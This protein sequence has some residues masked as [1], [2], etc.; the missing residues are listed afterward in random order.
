MSFSERI[1]QQFE[2]IAPNGERFFPSLIFT[3]FVEEYNASTFEYIEQIGTLVTR[4]FPKGR[5]FSIRI[6]FQGDSNIDDAERFRLTL[7]DRRP[8]RFFHPYYDQL[9]LQPISLKYDHSAYNVTVIT[10]TCIETIDDSFPRGTENV[11]GRIQ[12]DK[13]AF[14][15]TV[16]ES[17]ERRTTTLTP[18]EINTLGAVI[19]QA[20]TRYRPLIQTDDQASDFD[21]RVNLARNALSDLVDN[22]TDQLAFVNRPI[23]VMRQIQNVI[24]FIIELPVPLA[25]RL[26]TLVN[27]IPALRLEYRELLNL[28]AS[29]RAY[30]ESIFF[31]YTWSNGYYIGTP[32]RRRINKR[33]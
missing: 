3:E 6:E 27:F 21:N 14:D 26:D 16:L 2:I 32:N 8:F 28:L 30:Y 5:K 20:D 33:A 4:G 23:E 19:D 7:Q 31:I 11:A 18:T 13:D 9:V 12:D 22:A 15:D 1:Q 29:E 17:L 24:N 25:A 10:G